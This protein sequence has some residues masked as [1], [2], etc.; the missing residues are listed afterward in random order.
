M[1][2]E[3]YGKELTP[4]MVSVYWADLQHLSPEQFVPGL[5]GARQTSKFMPKGFEILEHAGC[6]T[7]DT[8]ADARAAIRRPGRNKKVRFGDR[9]INAILRVVFGSWPQFCDAF[10]EEQ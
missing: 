9:T 7:E 1:T 8:R 6:S 3:Y 10:H 5:T 2:A 4:P